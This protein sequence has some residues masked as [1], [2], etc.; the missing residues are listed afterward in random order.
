MV[1]A[2]SHRISRALCY[3]G[4]FQHIKIQLQDFQ[5]YLVL[6]SKALLSINMLIKV[7]QPLNRFRLFSVSSPLI[8][9]SLLLSFP[10]ATKMFQFTGLSKNLFNNSKFVIGCPIRESLDQ[11]L[12]LVPQSISL[13]T[14]PFI[15]S[16][17]QAIQHKL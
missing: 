14:T 4:K 2:D 15:D 11:N 9:K 7:P 3:L 17:C 10:P 12:F 8:R 1:L 13:V 16:K 6:H 5:P